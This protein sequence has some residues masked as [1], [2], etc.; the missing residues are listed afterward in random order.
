MNCRAVIESLSDYIDDNV[1]VDLG[2]SIDIHLESCRTC[3]GMLNTFQRTIDFCRDT[4]VPPLP[5]DVR[6]SLRA[7]V[8]K[9]F[10]KSVGR[11]GES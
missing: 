4:S 9:A 1:D 3:K 7:D 5:S 8:R 10:E 11:Q 2:D 6:E